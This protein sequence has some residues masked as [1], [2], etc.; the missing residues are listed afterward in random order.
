MDILHLVDRLETLINESRRVPISGLRMVDEERALELIDQMRITVPEEVKKAKRIQQ[1]KDRI[2]AQAQE[3]A[4]R[5]KELAREEAQ[6]MVSAD[7]ITR[8]A[9][10]RAE[11]ILDKAR[12]EGEMLLDQGRNEAAVVK[13]DADEYVLQALSRLEADL[14]RALTQVQNGLALVRQQ[15]AE[16]EMAQPALNSHPHIPE[17]GPVNETPMIG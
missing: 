16:A 12:R 15:Q 10:S 13:A 9:E 1:E 5:I 14:S 6:R 7:S 8:Q 4:D 3:E 2:M 17:A 11:T